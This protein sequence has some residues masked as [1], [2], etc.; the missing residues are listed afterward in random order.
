[1]SPALLSAVDQLALLRSGGIS[2]LDLAE[3]H[4]RRIERL[5]PALRAYVECNGELV[6]AE[7][8]D[9]RAGRLAGLPVAIKS[10]ID[11][12]GYRCESGSRLRRGL[13]AETDAEAVRKLRA[14]GAVILGKTNCP[15]FLMNYETAND[16]YG[17][18]AN[19]WN[20]NY[21]AGGSSG[22]TAS[23]IAAGLAACGLGSDSGGSVRQRAH[24]VGICALKPTPGR[25]S[26]IGAQ[27]PNAGP[28]STL[29]AVGPM[30]RTV[31]DVSLLFEVL[32][33]G[34]KPYAPAD[35]SGATVGWFEDDSLVPVTPETRAAVRSAA[36]AL[37]KAGLRVK[38]FR[39]EGLEEARR[40]WRLFFVQC[41]AMVYEPVVAGHRGRLSSMFEDFLQT[42]EAEPPL[43]GS[44]L[45]TAWIEA[46]L[47]RTRFRAAMQVAGVDLLLMPACAIP[48]FRHGERAW[49]VDGQT[50]GYW[51]AMRYTQWWNLLAMPAAVVPVGAAP[52][53][54]PIGVQIAGPAYEDELVLAAAGIVNRAFGRRLLYDGTEANIPQ[55]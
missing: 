43:T 39:P 24:A 49:V 33:T 44:A 2:P 1:M 46:D 55:R 25:I 17:R 30:A 21:S 35:P 10:C 5:N 48:A 20:L 37:E 8:R 34:P 45:L 7:A 32:C 50:V 52:N 19:P 42:A 9:V 3:E 14:E 41:G 27:P 26:D 51:D 18:T 40:L 38:A 11:V 54:L 36:E 28:F 22:G 47:L 15:E 4:L 6:R 23:A 53:G 12:A 29:G 13:L 31:A 16:L